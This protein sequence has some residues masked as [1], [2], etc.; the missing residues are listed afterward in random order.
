MLTD[1]GGPAI[2]RDL[3]MQ[4]GDEGID[5]ISAG[6]RDARDFEDV[7]AGHVLLSRISSRTVVS[8]AAQTH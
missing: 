2:R 5:R 4:H 3:G 1:E 6:R 8:P 7:I